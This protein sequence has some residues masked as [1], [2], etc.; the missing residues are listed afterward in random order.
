MMTE[1][2]RLAVHIGILALCLGFEVQKKDGVR[3][4]RSFQV[5]FDEVI[6]NLMRYL[7]MLK[8]SS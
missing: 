6:D 5:R 1:G 3:G 8:W 2:P 7:V 4:K